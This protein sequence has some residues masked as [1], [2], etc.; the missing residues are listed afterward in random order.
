MTAGNLSTLG[1]AAQSAPFIL[2]TLLSEPGTLLVDV[3]THPGS[4]RYPEWR[5]KALERRYSERYVHIPAFGNVHYRTPEQPIQLAD[6]A[7][8]VRWALPLLHQGRSLVLL[9]DDEGRELAHSKLLSREIDYPPQ[10]IE[11]ALEELGENDLVILYQ[12]VKHRYYQLTRWSQWQS[13]SSQKMIPSKYPA[14][15]VESVP[16][17][18]PPMSEED[19]RARA[20]LSWHSPEIRGEMP[21]NVG[22]PQGNSGKNRENLSQYNLSESKLIQEKRIEEERSTPP[23]V[24]LFPTT[25]DDDNAVSS[26]SESFSEVRLQI[27]EILHLPCSEGLARII[28]DYGEIPELSLVGEADAAREW[29]DDP[30]RNRKGQRMSLAFFRRW[31][32]REYEASRSR[33]MARVSTGV[34]PVASTRAQAHIATNGAGPPGKKS[35]TGSNPYEDFVKSRAQAGGKA[36]E[37]TS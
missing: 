12:G 23:N 11:A 22:N 29:L 37:E 36:H 5:A 21:G 17:V 25:R 7:S 34:S 30:A 3:R 9:A 27:A 31:L 1:Y 16:A 28:A 6:P 18:A 13:I 20:E 35:R 15:P 32:Q 24:V 2:E 4:H 19:Q 14:P 33:Q 26:L 8:G 10:Q